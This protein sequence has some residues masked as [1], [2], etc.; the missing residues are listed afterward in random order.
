MMLPKK[1]N[2]NNFQLDWI[3]TA[4]LYFVNIFPFVLKHLWNTLRKMLSYP[5]YY[6]HDKGAVAA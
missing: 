1:K 4:H 3:F 2:N 6:V 5:S